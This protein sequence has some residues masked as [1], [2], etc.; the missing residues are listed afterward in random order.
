VALVGRVLFPLSGGF[1]VRIFT[2]GEKGDFFDFRAWFLPLESIFFDIIFFD[3]T[4]FPSLP[5]GPTPRFFDL[6]VQVEKLPKGCEQIDQEI[7]VGTMEA[8]M[9][10][11]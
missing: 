7:V 9:I 1:P 6:K 4:N 8:Q 2:K 3:E 10:D 11:C 5:L